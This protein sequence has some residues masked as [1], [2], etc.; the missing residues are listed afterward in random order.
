METM[1]YREHRTEY[2]ILLDKFTGNK[3]L[4]KLIEECQ[5]EDIGERE[6][7]YLNNNKYPE[8]RNLLMKLKTDL[9]L[10]EKGELR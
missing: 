10:N 6:A 1:R 8:Q 4:L 2:Q 5:I 9:I 3:E 7:F